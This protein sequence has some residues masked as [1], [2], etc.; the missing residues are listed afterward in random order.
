MGMI[1]ARILYHRGDILASER[2]IAAKSRKR[3]KSQDARGL[4][5][6]F[7]SGG[8]KKKWL[9]VKNSHLKIAKTQIIVGNH[10]GMVV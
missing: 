9:F 8:G 4:W 7:G 3:A 6:N 1:C 10:L 5:G 2:E